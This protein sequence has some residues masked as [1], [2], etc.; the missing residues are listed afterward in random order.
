MSD[1]H[2]S[3]TSTARRP[4]MCSLC[5]QEIPKGKIMP[6][7]QVS[8]AGISITSIFIYHVAI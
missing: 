1:F 2:S 7:G 3:R 8:G 4:H 5:G 6:G